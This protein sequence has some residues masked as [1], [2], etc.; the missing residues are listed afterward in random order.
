MLKEG[1]EAQAHLDH[2]RSSLCSES[3]CVYEKPFGPPRQTPTEGEVAGEMDT[4]VRKE[5]EQA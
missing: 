2:L 1:H 4:A 3:L 5:F